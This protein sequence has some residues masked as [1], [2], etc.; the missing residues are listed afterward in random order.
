[1]FI[2]KTRDVGSGEADFGRSLATHSPQIF[3]PFDIP[4]DGNLKIRKD[5]HFHQ[6]IFFIY[7]LVVLT[8]CSWGGGAFFVS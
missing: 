6:K 7:F 5:H 2:I 8:A 3:R 1:M 4:E